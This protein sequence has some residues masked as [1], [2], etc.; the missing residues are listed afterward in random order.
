MSRPKPGI[1]LKDRLLA[2]RRILRNG[3]WKWT[4][5]ESS[6]GYGSM[7]V[8]GKCVLPHRV[9]YSVF[10]GKIPPDILVCHQCDFKLCI[11]PSHLF[12]GN[13]SDNN[14]DCYS[15]NRNPNARLTQ[16]KLSQIKRLVQRGVFY[17]V[18]AKQFSI[19]KSLIS[20]WK[21]R[22]FNNGFKN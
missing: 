14:R 15:K 1:T 7:W 20:H 10:V 16:R 5:A 11:N 4:G 8:G 3:C 2:K 22:G 18:I 13:D 6:S 19:S 9:S 21:K 17:K 12:L